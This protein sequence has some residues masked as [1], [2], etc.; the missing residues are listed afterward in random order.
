MLSLMLPRYAFAFD[1]D[2]AMP[3]SPF[4]AP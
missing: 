3:V 1:F 4:F 2:A